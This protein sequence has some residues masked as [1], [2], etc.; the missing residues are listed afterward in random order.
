MR[1]Q[2]RKEEWAPFYTEATGP[3]LSRVGIGLSKHYLWGLWR[4]TNPRMAH[5]LKG[6]EGDSRTQETDQPR[7]IIL[8]VEKI[9]KK[10]MIIITL[11][12][13]NRT[14]YN[15]FVKLFHPVGLK[16]I[17]PNHSVL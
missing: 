4:A 7:D 11:D 3:P 8:I 14:V 10:I 1:G 9:I 12:K 15:K 16:D 2:G 13:N 17:G 5:P 6:A